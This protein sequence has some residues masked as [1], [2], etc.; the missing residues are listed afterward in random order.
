MVDNFAWV[1]PPSQT[2]QVKGSPHCECFLCTSAVD[3]T[4][5]SSLELVLM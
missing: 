2:Q 5:P 4:V 3:D 1:D